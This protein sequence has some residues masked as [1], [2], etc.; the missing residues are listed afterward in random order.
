MKVAVLFS[1]GK[2]S[3][4]ASYLAKQEH[5]ISC[6]I[7]L[8]SKSD[9]S[10][11]FHVPNIELVKLQ[12]ELMGVP[13]L[14][15]KTEGVK[16]E[17]LEDLKNAIIEAKEKY[18][19]EG[20]F[21]GALASSYQKDR[22]EKICEDLGIKS[23]SPLWHIDSEEYINSLIRDKFKVII[24]GIAADGFNESWLGRVIDAKFLEDIKKLNIHIGG[25][26]GEYESLVV[27]CPLFKNGLRIIESKNLL[28]NECTG[29]LIVEKAE[30]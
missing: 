28:E 6:L 30:I 10:W 5:E 1:G 13:I 7:S 15:R 25:E 24:V 20:I 21:S 4:Y 16:E 23:V 14:Y 3:V 12:A 22:I 29:K 27:D 2:D 18:G 8:E 9:E 19:I 26:G 11:M 17:E